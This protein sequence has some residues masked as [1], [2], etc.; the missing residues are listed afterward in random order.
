MHEHCR[1]AEI[2]ALNVNMQLRLIGN[3]LMLFT[4]LI[5]PRGVTSLSLHW[6]N[7]WKFCVGELFWIISFSILISRPCDEP[8]CHLWNSGSVIIYFCQWFKWLYQ[9]AFCNCCLL[10]EHLCALTNLH[11]II[12][13][14][15][16]TVQ[17]LKD[18]T[19]N[20]ILFMHSSTMV[21]SII[22]DEW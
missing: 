12:V 18:N 20:I 1:Y 22:N 17:A 16:C 7:G 10:D 8:R 21:A 13:L 5:F 4:L 3:K 15:D 2:L 19:R 9:L 6:K 11:R 14:E